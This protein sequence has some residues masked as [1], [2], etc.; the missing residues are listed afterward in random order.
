MLNPYITYM[1]IKDADE[2]G[3]VVPPG[4]GIGNIGE[5]LK[6]YYAKGG[7]N[8]TLEP[9]LKALNVIKDL[10]QNFDEGQLK[11]EIYETER[12]AFDVAVTALNSLI[13][14]V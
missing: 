7:R 6:R 5:L 9:H 11:Q 13:K 3:I 2:N 1:H 4:Q 12:E 14:E 8:L 10:E